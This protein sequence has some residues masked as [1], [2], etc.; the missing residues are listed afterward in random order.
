MEKENKVCTQ[1]QPATLAIRWS[2]IAATAA[3]V[4][5]GMVIG[6]V[7]VQQVI[8]R[9]PVQFEM[10]TAGTSAEICIN[11]FAYEMSDAE[12]DSPWY[13]VYRPAQQGQDPLIAEDGHLV[14]RKVI[15]VHCKIGGQ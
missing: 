5:F 10:F 3:G 1:T 15:P 8:K 14:L 11:G 12:I 9:H 2:T 7:G 13:G 6:A 4:C